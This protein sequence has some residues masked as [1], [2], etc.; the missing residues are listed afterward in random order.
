[1]I[2]T[3]IALSC[4]VKVLKMKPLRGFMFWQEKLAEIAK[5]RK[6]KFGFQNMRFKVIL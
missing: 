4:S 3:E 6:K 1:M 5:T 2:S